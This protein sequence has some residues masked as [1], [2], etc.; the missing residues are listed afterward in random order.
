MA[1]GFGYLSVVNRQPFDQTEFVV[2]DKPGYR[3]EL[4]GLRGLAVLLVL[5][6]HLDPRLVPGGYVGVDVFFVLSG[7]LVTR[8]IL[9]DLDAGEFCFTRFFPRRLRRLAPAMIVTL[10]LTI[11]VGSVLMTP[12]DFERLAASAQWHLVFASNHFFAGEVGYFEPAA[13]R[14]PLLH[15]WSLAVEE[16]FYLA[17]PFL[18][19]PLA[20]ARRLLVPAMLVGVAALSF[21]HACDLTARAPGYSYFV[22]SARAWELAIGGLL[23]T[24]WI[25]R[26]A[27]RWLREGLAVV[28]LTAVVAA[29]FLYDPNTPFP[30]LFAA[31]PVVGAA[32]YVLGNDR[33]LEERLA[34]TLA[35]LAFSNHV[36][37]FVGLISYSLY[38]VHWPVVAFTNYMSIGEPGLA[39]KATCGAASLVLATLSWRLVEQPVRN[40]RLLSQDTQLLATTLAGAV[41]VA[42]WPT[43]VSPAARQA[44]LPGLA[45]RREADEEHGDWRVPLTLETPDTIP[46]VQTDQVERGEWYRLGV[47]G[48]PLEV[49]V[50][51]D[52]HARVVA[53][54]VSHVLKSRG[55]SGLAIFWGGQPPLLGIQRDT[56][57]RPERT[58][59]WATATVEAILEQ[60]PRA[61]LLVANWPMYCDAGKYIV[62]KSDDHSIKGPDA[63]A[64]GLREVV[65]RFREVEIEVFV[66]R[67][68]PRQ[69]ER[70]IGRITHLTA[71]PQSFAA[72][73]EEVHEDRRL[74][75]QVFAD[76]IG[77]TVVDP[78]DVLVNESGRTVVVVDG[79]EAYSDPWHLSRRGALL[80]APLFEFD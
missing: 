58:S 71:D 25:R 24:T 45:I 22:L 56:K 9:R 27:P 47:D 72:S 16:Q 11:F 39:S 57:N 77:V 32:A 19:V 67:G 8:V 53:P 66:M 10:L 7:Y 63:V 6:H 60:K 20:R 78:V 75:D 3:P 5:L 4:D 18:L 42:V 40:R 1:R 54:V 23:A 38:L 41:V 37:V 65:A 80:L 50:W 69:S 59:E 44:D 73:A 14:T 17:Y 26:P 36:V 79:E 62:L 76:L 13:E 33:P 51:G 61:V 74:A 70:G 15:F 28:G 52:S 64:G 43:L 68:V 31:L 2:Q 49:A 30:S 21:W 48:G 55:Q 12:G 34:P 46:N 29:S 35:G